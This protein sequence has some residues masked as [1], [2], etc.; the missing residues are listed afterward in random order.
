MRFY[1]NIF[2]NLK[3]NCHN[4]KKKTI[5]NKRIFTIAYL[6]QAQ[7]NKEQAMI[8]EY[9]GIVWSNAYLRGGCNCHCVYDQLNFTSPNKIA[10]CGYNNLIIDSYYQWIIVIVQY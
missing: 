1:I 8:L 4:I 6:K 5:K 9:M 7:I 3:F 2:L 10:R